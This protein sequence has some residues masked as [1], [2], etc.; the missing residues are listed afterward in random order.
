MHIL[1]KRGFTLIELMVVIS[2]IAILS[3]IVLLSLDSARK[4][5]RDSQRIADMQA[6]LGSQNLYYSHNNYFFTDNG[7]DGVPDVNGYLT[8]SSDP[9]GENYI[10]EDNTGCDPDGEYFCVYATLEIAADDCDYETY[11]AVSEKGIETICE[12]SQGLGFTGTGCNCW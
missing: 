7:T 8:A 2:V 11:I 3:T 1:D 6:V 10:W 5:A 12:E 9:Q 4:D